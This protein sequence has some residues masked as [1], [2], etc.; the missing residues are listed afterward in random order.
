VAAAVAGSTR[1][2]VAFFSNLGACYVCRIHDVPPSTGYGDPV[3]KLFKLD[4]NERMVAVYS[5]DPRS[6]DVP[7]PSE[8]AAEPEPPYALAVTR[9]GLGLRF[10]LRA[11]REPS[12][13]AGRKF[14]KLNEGD[15]I[16]AVLIPAAGDTVLCA[17]TD[18]HALGVAVDLVPVL[19]G[20]GKGSI[21][22]RIDESDRL[23]GAVAASQSDDV[24]VVETEKG[25]RHELSRDKILGSRADRGGQIVKRDRFARIVPPPVAIPKLD[26]GAQ[27][28]PTAPS[29]SGPASD[30]QKEGQRATPPKAPQEM[31]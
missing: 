8:D 21:L 26:L 1:A 12:T 31:N 18:G 4:D 28:R 6:I 14:A 24:L 11:H 22:M 20:A 7:Q 9:A 27:G 23:L 19:S 2:S 10:S 29:A 25:K 15:E 16:I 17:S 5:L 13:R 30:G 3:Q